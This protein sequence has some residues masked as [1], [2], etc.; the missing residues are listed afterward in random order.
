VTFAIG[1]G[2]SGATSLG[3]MACWLATHLHRAQ[4]SR[5]TPFNGSNIMMRLARHTAAVLLLVVVG[6]CASSSSATQAG[7]TAHRGSS[8]VLTQDELAATATVNVYDAIQR[9]RPQWLTSS[10]V[11]RGAS[12][13]P[14][15]VYLDN[16]R[17]GTVESLR[18]LSLAGIQEIRWLSASEATNR[19]GTGNTG[20]AIVVLMA[21]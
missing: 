4:Y 1:E 10:R 8:T 17:Y 6:A 18:G 7:S 20:G 12:G 13:D 3:G 14:T 2:I 21:K 9:L 19:W 16:N 11:R 5:S 15:Q